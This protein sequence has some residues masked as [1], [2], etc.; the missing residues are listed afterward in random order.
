MS[1][2]FHPNYW[3]AQ[4]NTWTMVLRENLSPGGYEAIYPLY[5]W[6][7]VNIPPCVNITEERLAEGPVEHIPGKHS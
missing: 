2:S 1:R 5:S 3:A 7:Q 4:L 6:F